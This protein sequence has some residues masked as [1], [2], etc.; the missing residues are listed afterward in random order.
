MNK[1]IRIIPVIIA[2]L[3]FGAA[4]VVT[5][6]NVFSIEFPIGE[7]GNC[8][9][10]QEC[11]VFCD[12][13]VNGDACFAFA[14]A[15]GLVKAE[16]KI[17]H[18]EE[19]QLEQQR[20]QVLKEAG[21]GPGGCDSEE[22]CKTF[23]SDS[24]NAD[25]CLAFARKHELR[26]KE[27]LDRIESNVGE[28]RKKE[29]AVRAG[30]GPGGCNSP[31][32]CNT[33]CREPANR[34][35]CLDFAKEHNLI[36]PEELAR[37]EKE[38]QSNQTGPGGCASREECDTFCRTPKNVQVCLDF[39]VDKGQISQEQATQFKQMQTHGA[40]GNIRSQ[41]RG[42]QIRTP[43]QPKIDE[44]K[45]RQLLETTGG[46]GGCSSFEECGAFCSDQK[47]EE[48]CFNFAKENSLMS[49][50]DVG[51]IEKI[52]TIQGPGGCRGR[53]CEQTC[54]EQGREEECLN[55]AIDNGLIAPEDVE[56]AKKFIDIAK[57]GGP[58]GCKGRQCED[59]CNRPE[60]GDQC[61]AFAKEKGLLPQEE[62]QKIEKIQGT[63]KAGGGPGGCTSEQACRG[64]CTD[65]SHF[66]ECAAF[67][68]G[69]GLVKPEEAM[70]QLQQFVGAGQQQ[71]FG[72]RGPQ[73][74]GQQGGQSQNGQQGFGQQGQQGFGDHGSTNFGGQGQQMDPQ[75]QQ[76]F[77]ER[78]K[79]FQQF[80]S[81]FENGTQGQQNFGGGNG[82][83]DG[84][85][86]FPGQGNTQGQFPGGGAT[87]GNFPGGQGMPRPTGSVEPRPGIGN[88]QGVPTGMK[89]GG[90]AMPPN[91][92]G[93]PFDTQGFKEQF[94]QQMKGQ[95]EGQMNEQ[96][97]QEFKKQ[98][99]EEMKRQ[100]QNGGA[101]GQNM[102]PQG[103]QSGMFRPG[104]GTMGDTG[105]GGFPGQGG[106]QG[107]FG[108]PGMS[109]QGM[110][111]PGMGQSG[112]FPPNG[113]QGGF[114]QSGMGQGLPP[115]ANPMGG[116]MGQP[117]QTGGTMMPP[118]GMQDGGF[119][120]PEGS[121]GGFNQ[122]STGFP[123]SSGGFQQPS[124]GTMPPM[125]SPPPSGDSGG[126]GMMP[127]PSGSGGMP[128]PG[129]FGDVTRVFA[130]VFQALLQVFK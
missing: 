20:K 57:T 8:G 51:K 55:F 31:E 70:S 75:M 45:A 103:D 2:V 62:I 123:P 80:R 94:D 34:Q 106:G 64:Y 79:Q 46:P 82:F 28:I 52:R 104:A 21:T 127:P 130:A 17:K 16:D 56:H 128:P 32:T 65:T 4:F 72:Q 102:M 115:Q 63:L 119:H 83:P 114:G 99:E 41:V 81:Q 37:I 110:Q 29:E 11:K 68:V 77:E 12:D 7:L 27:E 19:K 14:Q 43:Q 58:G 112:G 86:G 69:A 36:P 39:A 60:N 67:A 74:F 66:E 71:G 118:P 53:Q 24:A 97:N 91:G 13:P 105:K 33:F 26:P 113:T 100:M 59:F 111:Q 50:E 98:Y 95:V 89:P 30:N 1:N 78:F 126:G 76:Q 93:M 109:Q 85:N 116:P 73:G 84:A 47:N 48:T 9:S 22:S 120:P 35:T 101:Q 49:S 107:Q 124:G 92:Q 90:T 3:L 54:S 23:C 125:M 129:A 10:L 40:M 6:Q 25:E 117:G 121:M 87:Q 61:L 108:Q 96:F 122:G 18:E 88:T 38:G 42:P 44:D 15:H 5:A